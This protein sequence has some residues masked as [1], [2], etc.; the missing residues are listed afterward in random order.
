MYAR[1]V[2]WEGADPDAMRRSAQDIERQAAA[3]PPEGVPAKGFLLMIAPD[4][5]RALAVMLF[6][7]EADYAQGDATLNAMS[8]PEDGMG[9]RTAVDRYEVAVDYR[10]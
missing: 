10:P 2:T 4:A 1:V 7:N 3:G 8:P 9:R 6:E 5:G